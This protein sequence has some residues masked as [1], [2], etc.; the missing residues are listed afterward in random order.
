MAGFRV[1]VDLAIQLYVSYPFCM[2]ARSLARD[3]FFLCTHSRCPVATVLPSE[4]AIACKLK[5]LPLGGPY[6]LEGPARSLGSVRME[7]VRGR[8]KF[9]EV[10][11]GEPEGSQAAW[12]RFQ[13]MRRALPR[14]SP[15]VSRLP[16]RDS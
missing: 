1:C 8:P 3:R 5:S 2:Y 12:R 4:R 10:S 11:F 7:K 16:Y 6:T 13:P 9:G 14:G 15:R